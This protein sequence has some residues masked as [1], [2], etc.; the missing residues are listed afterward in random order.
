MDDNNYYRENAKDFFSSTV[1]VS[2]EP[3]YKRFFDQVVAGGR[4]LDAGCGSGRD[5]KFFS[6]CG[7]KV[8]AFD[9]SPELAN[10]ASEYCGFEVEVRTFSELDEESVYD[11]IWC[12]ASLLHVPLES[13]VATITSIWRALKPGGCFYASYKLGTGERESGGRRFTDAD[14]SQFLKWIVK[15]E[16]V[17]GVETWIT[18]DQRPGREEKWLNVILTRTPEYQKKLVT[19]GDDHLLPHL[20]RAIAGSNDIAFTVAFVKVTGLRLLLPDIESALDDVD[21]VSN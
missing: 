21:S 5:A 10:L 9:S 11:G 7:Y 8:F 15:L 14:E 19:G 4:I 12:C 16:E 20:S 17:S 2:M 18:D 13:M 3:I 1:N 6:Q